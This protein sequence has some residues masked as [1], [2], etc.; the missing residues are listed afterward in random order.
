MKQMCAMFTEKLGNIHILELD[1]MII[2]LYGI[3]VQ[4]G[5]LAT[6]ID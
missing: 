2:P 3:L 5:N 4:Y 6:Q 1:R